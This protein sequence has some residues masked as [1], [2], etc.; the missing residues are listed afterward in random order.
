[1]MRYVEPTSR[2]A[3]KRLLDEYFR[4]R[5]TIFCDR[6]GWVGAMADGREIDEFDAFD[7][8][9]NALGHPP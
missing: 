5:K 3:E 2:I 1:M 7:A 4:L 6:L 8:L 9:E